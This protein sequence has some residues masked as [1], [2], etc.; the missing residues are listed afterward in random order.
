MENQPAELE[1]QPTVW[2]RLRERLEQMRAAL[3]R[4]SDPEARAKK[5]ADLIREVVAQND[6][7]KRASHW[8]L[9]YEPLSIIVL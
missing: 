6:V 5:L 2:D 8:R 4:K 7:R 9:S 1:N 3:G